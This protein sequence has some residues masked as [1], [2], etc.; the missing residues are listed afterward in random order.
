VIVFYS[1][2]GLFL[3]AHI[4]MIV[5]IR[6]AFL[7]TERD[8]V[9]L[10]LSIWFV[11]AGILHFT[12]TQTELLMMP[13]ILPFK[14][15]L[16]YISGVAEIAGGIGLMVPRWQR[17]AA[18]GLVFLLLAVFPANINAAINDIQGP[19]LINDRVLQWVRLPLQFVL[20][21]IIVWASQ[22]T[23]VPKAVTQEKAV[24]Q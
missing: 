6:P 11:L 20:I 5:G 10:A 22:Q 18:F 21:G 3:A 19:G 12:A 9:R 15:A 1:L 16:M 2:I 13:P 23:S 8:R 4:P 17:P 7:R 14:V 24:A